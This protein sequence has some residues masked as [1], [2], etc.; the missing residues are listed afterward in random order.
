MPGQY[1]TFF[2]GVIT[3]PAFIYTEDLN[4]QANDK[5]RINGAETTTHV[6]KGLNVF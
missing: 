4:A 2:K 6:K 5:V 3:D 1:P